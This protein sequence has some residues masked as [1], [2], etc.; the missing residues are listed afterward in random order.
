MHIRVVITR[1]GH[2][3]DGFCFSTKTPP[4]LFHEK[5]QANDKRFIMGT[6]NVRNIHRNSSNLFF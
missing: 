2:S 5:K 4:G 3:K 1:E 6:P